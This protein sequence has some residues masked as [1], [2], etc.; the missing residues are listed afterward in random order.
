MLPVSSPTCCEPVL[1]SLGGV[2]PIPLQATGVLP[3][4]G[5]GDQAPGVF[6]LLAVPVADHRLRAF[7]KKTYKQCATF[8]EVRH[9]IVIL[10]FLLLT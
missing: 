1:S 6:P 3:I 7:I 4:K 10:C 8:P 2:P 5:I 9:D